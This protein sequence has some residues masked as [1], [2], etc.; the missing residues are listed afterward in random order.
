MF[1]QSIK[2]NEHHLHVS[3][4]NYAKS[5]YAENMP[6]K[7]LMQCWYFHIIW[8]RCLGIVNIPKEGLF[9]QFQSWN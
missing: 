4:L 7:E 3:Q 5:N 2:D 8:I 1:S 9:S 6:H